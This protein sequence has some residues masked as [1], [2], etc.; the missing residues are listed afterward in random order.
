MNFWR[1]NR[2]IQFKARIDLPESVF[3]RI[4]CN[5]GRTTIF[6]LALVGAPHL[7]TCAEPAARNDLP[8]RLQ[9]ISDK[10]LEAQRIYSEAARQGGK[11]DMAALREAHK[12]RTEELTALAAEL[13]A[14]PADKQGFVEHESLADIYIQLRQW[15]NAIKHARA[16]LGLQ[17][18]APGVHANLIAGLAELPDLEAAETAFAKALKVCADKSLIEGQHY[19]LY[20]ANRR[21]ERPLP[22]AE[23]LSQHLLT[24]RP[25]ATPAVKA[26]YMRAVDDLAKLL[27]DGEQAAK[28]V[29]LL[30]TEIAFWKA[31]AGDQTQQA[32]QVANELITKKIAALDS[33][34]NH[35]AAADLLAA[36][37][38]EAQ[39][40]LDAQP[41]G[42]PAVLRMGMLL[43]AKAKISDVERQAE[44]RAAWLK[45]LADQ[46]TAQKDSP[47]IASAMSSAYLRQLATLVA[48]KQEADV[49]SLLASYQTLIAALPEGLSTA[50]TLSAAESMMKSNL[51]RLVAQR[52]Q[53]ELVG[54]PMIPL[55]VAAWANGSPLTAEDLKGKV[56]LLD[57]WAVW[58]GPCRATFPHLTAWHEKYEKDGLVVIGL[59]RYYQYGWDAEAKEHVAVENISPTDEVA[60]VE[61]FAKH[62]QLKHRLAY[63]PEESKLSEAYGVSGIPHVVVIDRQGMIR[64]IRVGSGE[65][66]AHDI[67][68][69]LE[70]LV[71][72]KPAN[73][74][75]EAKLDVSTDTSTPTAG[76]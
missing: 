64:M 7:A 42:A 10:V 40:Q 62:H 11:P 48:A 43:E 8:A 25:F 15:D 27:I 54:S 2:H 3:M 33:A 75:A 19:R 39:Q 67:E 4:F 56:V 65:P 58:C 18:D 20:L 63:M 28:A 52:M 47:E 76:K 37:L 72:E 12:R 26:G 66:N 9:G 1:S 60:A 16:A 55:E 68:T 24:L 32:Q 74:P 35:A 23:H 45:F 29:D 46:F 31:V 61:Q 59:T 21:A 17:P 6:C 53:D 73:A 50:K 49:E 13:E 14:L 5:A 36:Q 34:G 44:A 22:A 70:Q 51:R 69:L 41:G 57:F 71:H 38:T 30:D